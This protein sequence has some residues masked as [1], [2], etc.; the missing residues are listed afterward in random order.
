[1]RIMGLLRELLQVPQ[2][3]P[4]SE[5]AAPPGEVK[6]LKGLPP[7]IATAKDVFTWT[8]QGYATPAEHALDPK[9]LAYQNATE[10]DD[11]IKEISAQFGG[12]Q[13]GGHAPVRPGQ[14]R[15]GGLAGGVA[16]R[17]HGQG[18]RLR[19]LRREGLPGPPGRTGEHLHPHD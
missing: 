12:R 1:M 14:G 5:T 7:G 15:Q 3:K 8:D 11:A 18:V 6:F 2:N 4:G 13:G 9:T 19:R 16:G 10:L 17:G